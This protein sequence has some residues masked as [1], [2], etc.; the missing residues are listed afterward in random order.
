MRVGALVI[1]KT[2]GRVIVHTSR[3]L[4][5]LLV[6]AIGFVAVVSV[7]M[8]AG[9]WRLSQ[10]P[11]EL[12]W[13]ADRLRAILS[14]E[15][16]P[17]HVSFG[18]LMLAWEGFNKG[19][20]YP[21]DLDITEVDIT[22][23]SGRSLAAAPQAHLTFSAAAMLLGRFVPRSIEVDHA[24]IAVIRDPDGTIGIAGSGTETGGEPA[25][26]RTLRD[27]LARP[28]GTD[29]GMRPGILD[30]IRRVHFRDA[31]VTATDQK[32]GLVLKTAGMNIDLTRPAIG[33]VT[34]TLSAPL[35]LGDEKAD[36]FGHV[37]FVPGGNTR[38]DV[39]LSPFR[40]AGIHHPSPALAVTVP[41]S[42]EATVDFDAGFGVSRGFATVHCGQGVIP[43]GKGQFPLLD[44]VVS[45]AVAP[46]TLT[47]RSAHFN[48]ARSA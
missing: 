15:A 40:L 17:V 33:H 1:R 18:S 46:D 19:V 43:A 2:T 32:S 3:L 10:G 29:H 31:E 21:L 24:R 23:A 42:L 8:A 20:D 39:R 7:L 48:V 41:V 30:Q 4:H 22:D 34:G 16:G 38:L 47:I 26:F 45:L 28:A 5:R 27:Q 13:L 14:D 9:A 44:G 25:D 6:T 36:L 37:D 11:I 35:S 12:G